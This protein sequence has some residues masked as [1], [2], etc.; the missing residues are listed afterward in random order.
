MNSIIEEG[1]KFVCSLNDLKEYK[2][3]RF[4]LDN[5]EIA[6]FKINGDVF[7]LGNICP[8]QHTSLIYD[9]IIEDGC[10]VCPVHGWMFDL[11]TGK[12]KS[13][14]RGLDTY[15]VRINNSDV[16]IK[17]KPKEFSW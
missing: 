3:R 10:V 7:A 5:T 17:I 14:S 4:I 16:F 11:Q 6:I 12:K 2:G 9:G 1:F 13:G 8:H 15:N